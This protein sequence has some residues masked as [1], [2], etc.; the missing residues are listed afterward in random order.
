MRTAIF[1]GS[2]DPITFGHIEIIERGLKLFDS[3]IVS[4]GLNSSKKA[5]FDENLR[6]KWIKTYFANEPKVQ[7]SSYNSLTVD[8]AKEKQAE[9]ILRGVRNAS[10]AEYES[11]ISRL[12]FHLNKNIETVVL[13]CNPSLAHISSSFVREIYRYGGSLKGLV[14]DLILEDLE[15]LQSSQNIQN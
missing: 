14:P 4:I 7:V 10:D 2:F 11:H 8:F 13:L 5:L 12:N 9:F 6:I 3:V 1:P 15:K